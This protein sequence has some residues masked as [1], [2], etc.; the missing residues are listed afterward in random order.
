MNYFAGRNLKEML[1]DRLNLF[2]GLAFP[3]LILVLLY[4]LN[5]NIPAEA[6]MSLFK[7]RI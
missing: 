2:F 7:L 3:L 1:R 5:R 6:S 4:V